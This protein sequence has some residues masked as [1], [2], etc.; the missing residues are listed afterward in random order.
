MPISYPGCDILIPIGNEDGAI[1]CFIIQVKNRKYDIHSSKLRTE[2]MSSLNDAARAL[3]LSAPLGMTMAL[4][5]KG[6][7]G[8]S[9][10]IVQPEV[11]VSKRKTTSGQR[12]YKWP[13][14]GKPK[15]LWFL[16]T[17]LTDEIYPAIK[18]D[19]SK[20]SEDTAPLLR[21][22][23]DCNAGTSLPDDSDRL[24]TGRLM[25]LEWRPDLAPA[26]SES[27][28]PPEK[29]PEAAEGERVEDEE[30]YK[31][32]SDSESDPAPGPSGY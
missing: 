27:E 5:E 19:T 25:P 22:L 9:F 17:G 31:A 10:S 14:A 3:D 16:V 15:K 30:E 11:E 1:S 26:Q 4:R 29:G 12:G 32:D 8:H 6:E 24:Y 20:A 21:R 28:M 18:V 7:Q 13:V 2:T 23:L